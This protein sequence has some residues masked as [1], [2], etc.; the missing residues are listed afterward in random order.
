MSSPRRIGLPETIRM[1]HD[2]H[3]VDQLARPGGE[4][5]GRL[6]PIEDLEPNPDQ[7]RQAFG[8]LAELTASIREKGV[9]EPLLVRKVGGRF[10]IIAGERRYRAAVEAGLSE[11]PCVIRESSDAEMMELALVENLQRK[12]LTAFEEAD[13]LAVLSGKYGYTHEAMAEKLGKSRSSITESLSLAAMPEEIRQACRLAD[14]QSK[15]LLLQI[16]RQGNAEKMASLVE[17]LGREGTT[18]AEARRLARKQEGRRGRGRPRHFVF[19]FKPQGGA[20]SLNLQFK[21][22]QVETEEIIRTLEGIV[23]SLRRQA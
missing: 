10:E 19:R 8:D 17:R 22:G 15:S 21:Q 13:G 18:R 6:I 14:I 11:L 1:R 7:P 20:F 3:F 2:T 9:L 12:D 4:A 5:I 23:E 16:V